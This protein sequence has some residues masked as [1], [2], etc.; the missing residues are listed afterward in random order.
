MAVTSVTGFTLVAQALTADSRQNIR[1]DWTSGERWGIRTSF[2]KVREK[3]K[4]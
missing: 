4:L 2:L 1:T 3:L